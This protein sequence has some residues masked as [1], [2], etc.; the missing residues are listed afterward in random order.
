MTRRRGGHAR[1]WLAG[2]GF[3]AAVGWGYTEARD[4]EALSATLERAAEPEPEGGA[5]ALDQAL[6]RRGRAQAKVLTRVAKSLGVRRW[7]LDDVARERGWTVYAEA[8]AAHAATLSEVYLAAAEELDALSGP[9][10]EVIAAL[11]R[12][13]ASADQ[14]LADPWTKGRPAPR[15]RAMRLFMGG[16]EQLERALPEAGWSLDAPW[17]AAALAM[18]ARDAAGE[19]QRLRAVERAQADRARAYLRRHGRYLSALAESLPDGLAERLLRATRRLGLGLAAGAVTSDEL[20]LGVALTGR[21]VGAW[22]EG[23][24]A[25]APGQLRGMLDEGRLGSGAVLADLGR[26]LG[27]VDRLSMP[28]VAR[29]FSP[30]PSPEQRASRAPLGWRVD[31]LAA[32]ALAWVAATAGLFALLVAQLLTLLAVRRLSPPAAALPFRGWTVGDM[33]NLLVTGVLP[34]PLLALAVCRLHPVALA[35]PAPLGESP[36]P[37]FAWG[38]TWGMLSLHQAEWR[39]RTLV[40]AKCGLDWT[41]PAAAKAGHVLVWAGSWVLLTLCPRGPDDLLLVAASLLLAGLGFSL[42]GG[43]LGRGYD[44]AT[45][46]AL[47]QLDRR[48]QISGLGVGLVVLAG[49]GGLL[50]APH[51]EHALSDYARTR[52]E[53]SVGRPAWSH[54]GAQRQARSLLRDAPDRP[55]PRAERKRAR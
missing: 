42:H 33:L 20:E 9:G 4:W 55:L 26:P 44:K 19:L 18:D 50:L 39:A 35:G 28:V 16:L 36:A 3:L 54:S 30:W 10:P 48:V 31:W 21:A 52:V 27:V 53:Q 2:A 15:V 17:L 7:E 14:V 45:F 51:R 38:L 41:S 5:R 32:E 40:M 8:R 22:G 12:V 11:L 34:V 46:K 37:Y 29:G 13:E 43:L 23:M 1:W 6:W 49:L 24:G 47:E 25:P